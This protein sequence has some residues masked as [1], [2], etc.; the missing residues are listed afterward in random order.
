VRL[1]FPVYWRFA[2]LVR[3]RTR[4]SL[5][6]WSVDHNSEPS[7]VYGEGRRNSD[8]GRCA[9]G[10][11]HRNRLPRRIWRSLG[12]VGGACSSLC[13]VLLRWLLGLV[14]LRV[15][16]AE[17]KDLEIVVLRHEL[18]IFRRST[19]GRRSPRLTGYFSAPPADFC[20]ASDRFDE[21][22]ASEGME[23]IRTP[24]RT[25]QANGVAERCVR[26]SARNVSTGC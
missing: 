3:A 16:S 17:L 15:R 14:V 1:A 8:P 10:D 13:Y 11:N 2:G 24:F 4:E 9:A 20:R 12:Y 5:T 22:F 18:A 23:V 25:P 19:H 7:A 26:T 21:V 6:A